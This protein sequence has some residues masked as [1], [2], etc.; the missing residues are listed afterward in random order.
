M[1]ILLLNFQNVKHKI[2]KLQFLNNFKVLYFDIF[3]HKINVTDPELFLYYVQYLTEKNVKVYNYYVLNYIN[4]LK[5]FEFVNIIFIAF[6][7]PF[8]TILR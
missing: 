4:Y 5:I 1:F 2:A 7:L 6:I 8:L 3:R